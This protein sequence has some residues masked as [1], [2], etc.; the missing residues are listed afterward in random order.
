MTLENERLARAL[1]TTREAL[2][3]TREQLI[4]SEKMSIL[5]RMSAAVIH[6]LN[7]P[8]TTILGQT[9]MVLLNM[10]PTAPYRDD[11]VF[12]ESEAQRCRTVVQNLL[13]FSRRHKIDR[14]S[15]YISEVVQH[16]LRFIQKSFSLNS[17]HVEEHYDEHLPPVIAS[18]VH[19]T[20]VLLNLF[21]NAI[22]A[23]GSNG[24]LRIQASRQQ[25]TLRLTVTDTGSG[26]A[27]EVLPH[28]FEP[29][30]TT[31]EIGKGTGLGLAIS[32][33][34]VKEHRGRLEVQSPPPGETRGTEFA[35]VL[36]IEGGTP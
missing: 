9:Q 36:P 7:N 1:Q 28:I 21:Q 34:I 12:I 24:T 23:M 11:I 15:V 14:Q 18:P 8:M 33:M 4:Q 25:N 35:I 29:F 5:G 31:K 19:L 27:P 20:Q 26:I 17:I 10:E 6:E 13:Q 3:E 30:L 2:Q 22:D 16:A 32:Q